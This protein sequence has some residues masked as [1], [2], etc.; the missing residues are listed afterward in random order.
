[1]RIISRR[2]CQ[3]LWA[4][5]LEQGP[6]ANP[7]IF[8]RNPYYWKVDPAGNQLPYFDRV[9]MQQVFERETM[10]LKFASG[11]AT[12]QARHVDLER[13]PLFARNCSNQ[14]WMEQDGRLG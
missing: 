2:G 5:V 7:I 9:V 13:Y 3:R 14:A 11:E 1:M 10:Q 4:C 6:P 8:R 12:M